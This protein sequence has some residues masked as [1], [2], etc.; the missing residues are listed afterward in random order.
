MDIRVKGLGDN[1]MEVYNIDSMFGVYVKY[2]SFMSVLAPSS[3]AL[4]S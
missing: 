3:D 1:I 2:R 4:C